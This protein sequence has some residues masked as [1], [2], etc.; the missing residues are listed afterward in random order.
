MALPHP[1]SPLLHLFFLLLLSPLNPS[2]ASLPPKIPVSAAFGSAPPSSPYFS[3][4][5]SSKDFSII[6]TPRSHLVGKNPV[7]TR[8]HADALRGS[9]GD[10]VSSSSTGGVPLPEQSL[11]D[12]AVL[13]SNFGCHNP[14][15]TSDGVNAARPNV[16]PRSIGSLSSEAPTAYPSSVSWSSAVLKNQTPV[17]AL[18]SVFC[19]LD[20]KTP[21]QQQGSYLINCVELWNSSSRKTQIS[22]SASAKAHTGI[23]M[24]PQDYQQRVAI[25]INSHQQ[26]TMG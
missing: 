9:R 4:S 1:T 5:L 10:S 6:S 13:G 19:S 3:S 11:L 16:L 15:P 24:H 12:C 2:L 14:K 17:A 23:V 20:K 18:K 22:S 26:N 7:P 8:S 21:G 25:Q